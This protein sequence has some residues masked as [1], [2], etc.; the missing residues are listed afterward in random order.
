[1]KR[2]AQFAVLFVTLLAWVGGSVA[3]AWHERSVLHGV[4]PDDGEVIEVSITSIHSSKHAEVK[5]DPGAVHPHECEVAGIGAQ[6]VITPPSPAW[7]FPRS[8][9]AAPHRIVRLL[10]AARPPPLDYA[11][12]TS[13]PVG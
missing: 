9:D 5:V 7:S 1:M 4:C 12:K 6:G 8:G 2:A 10:Q 11:P 3:I 13:P